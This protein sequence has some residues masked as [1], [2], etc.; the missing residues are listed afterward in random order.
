M[1]FKTKTPKKRK[2]TKLPYEIRTYKVYSFKNAPP[3]L[4]EKILENYRYFN[5]EDI[6]LLEHNDFIIDMGLKEK[7]LKRVAETQGQGNTLFTWKSGS[8]N[9]GYGYNYVQFEDLKVND[10]EA[11]R[12]E[13][14]VSKRT[15]NKVH[16]SFDNEGRET[17]TEIEFDAYEELTPQQEKELEEAKEH[18]SYLMKQSAKNL[19]EDYEYQIS[20]EAVEEGL[21]ANEYK[22]NEQGKID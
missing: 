5:V 13:L 9:V 21:I 22:F 8:Y 15:W 11:F 17:N 16:Y 7:T 12:Q 6:N 18:F 19:N 4:K 20:D 2:A 10:E 14:G 1:A 3:K